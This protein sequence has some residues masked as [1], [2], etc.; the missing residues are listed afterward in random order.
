MPDLGVGKPM[1]IAMM[2]HHAGQHVFGHDTGEVRVAQRNDR[3]AGIGAPVA[4]EV[5]ETGGERECG[6]QPRQRAQ[7]AGRRLVRQCNFDRVDIDLA[8]PDDELDGSVV[9]RQFRPPCRRVIEI[10]DE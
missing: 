1:E 3:D 8:R 2:A 10:G 9:A 7:Q 6:T 4:V 5:I